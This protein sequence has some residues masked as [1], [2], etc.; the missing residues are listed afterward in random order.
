MCWNNSLD[1]N[2]NAENAD[3]AI[4]TMTSTWKI[5]LQWRLHVQNTCPHLL[6]FPNGATLNVEHVCIFTCVGIHAS[7]DHTTV[8]PSIPPLIHPSLL[9]TLHELDLCKRCRGGSE[10]NYCL[11]MLR[12]GSK[13]PP[14]LFG[15]NGGNFK[16][17]R[18]VLCLHISSCVL[19]A[20]P[21]RGSRPRGHVHLK[22]L[23]MGFDK[24]VY[25]A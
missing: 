21:T 20:G 16:D 11:S 2:A 25:G 18:R 10:M 12:E 15:I 4:K 1:L 3:A 19:T 7:S 24:A 9:S 14:C 17:K 13:W 23:W 8:H 22:A 6:G 5:S